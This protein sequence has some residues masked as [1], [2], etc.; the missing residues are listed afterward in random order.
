MSG[1]AAPRDAGGPRYAYQ[2]VADDI[3]GRIASGELAP[4]SRLRSERELAV[5]YQVAFHTVRRAMQLLR[6]RGLIRSI[7]GR[8]TYVTERD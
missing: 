2:R 8:G 1:N 7:H 6:D 4:G 3:A 5:H